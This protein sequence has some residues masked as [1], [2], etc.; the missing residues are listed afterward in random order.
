[1]KGCELD[2][3]EKTKRKIKAQNES[4]LVDSF[5]TIDIDALGNTA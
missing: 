2:G 3:Y 4:R 5:L 1:V